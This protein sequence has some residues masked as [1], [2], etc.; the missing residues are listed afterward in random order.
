MAILVWYFKT[1]QS[2]SIL[3]I[4]NVSKMHGFS[5]WKEEDVVSYL[6]FCVVS[7][8]DICAA[9]STGDNR[10]RL[11]QLDHINTLQTSHAATLRSRCTI[12]YLNVTLTPKTNAVL[13]SVCR[14]AVTSF[15]LQI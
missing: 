12:I 9:I 7:R 15:L 10:I 5:N 4:S 13:S 6:R 14:R 1:A 3:N 8:R 2:C 11:A